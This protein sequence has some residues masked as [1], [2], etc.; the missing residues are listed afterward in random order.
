MYKHVYIYIK[1]TYLCC[2]IH[3]HAHTHTICIGRVNKALGISDKVFYMLGDAVIGPA[4]GMFS[5]RCCC[6][7]Y[8]SV[9][10]SMLQY[11]AVC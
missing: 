5:V 2:R 7:A 6:S 8:C 10:C 1:Y 9:Y 11:V 3:T 4:I